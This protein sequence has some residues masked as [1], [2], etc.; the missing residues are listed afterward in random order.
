MAGHS[1]F[2]LF[3]V[4]N[5]KES[6]GFPTRTNFSDK[7][8]NERNDISLYHFYFLLSSF[9]LSLFLLLLLWDALAEPS[10]SNCLLFSGSTPRLTTTNC[11]NSQL[12]SSRRVDWPQWRGVGSCSVHRRP[13][14]LSTTDSGGRD[15]KDKMQCRLRRRAAGLCVISNVGFLL[16]GNSL[17]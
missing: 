14:R 3:S 13:R 9:S 16:C 1:K 12:P 6:D 15:S 11:S 7:E 8:R 2:S 10:S 4:W 5:L 17:V